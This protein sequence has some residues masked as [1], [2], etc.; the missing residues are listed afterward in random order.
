MRAGLT[1]RVHPEREKAATGLTVRV[2]RVTARVAA[3]MARVR[4]RAMRDGLTGL[5]PAS[6]AEDRMDRTRR[7]S[8]MANVLQVRAAGWVPVAGNLKAARR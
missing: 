8:V 1:G 2:L 4:H 7:A 6:G 3:R 5:P